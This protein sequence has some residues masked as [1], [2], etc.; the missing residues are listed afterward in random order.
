MRRFLP[1]FFCLIFAFMVPSAFAE[2]FLLK[3]HP[4]H[5]LD[6]YI[7]DALGQKEVS[8]VYVAE[9]GS[10]TPD[11]AKKRTSYQR[12]GCEPFNVMRGSQVIDEGYHCRTF[13][14]TGYR[15]SAKICRTN[16]GKPF[17]GIVEINRRTALVSAK[18]ERKDFTELT[19]IDRTPAVQKR[20]ADLAPLACAP[21]YM[22]HWG[23]VIGEGYRCQ[24]IGRYPEFSPLTE[25]I[26][27]WRHPVGFVCTIELAKEQMEARR[28]IVQRFGL[29]A[30]SAS[31]SM[32]STSSQASLSSSSAPAIPV[33]F[34]DVIS[35]YYGYTAILSLAERGVV[36]GYPDGTFR[37]KE[38]VNR[39]EF[40]KMLLVGL[41]PDKANEN[42]ACFPDIG[43]QWYAPYVCAAKRE[44]WVGGYPDGTFR[45]GQ[46]IRRA[47]GLKIVM[48]A[49]GASLD[50]NAPLPK[51]VSSGEWFTPYVRKAV[52]MRI[53]LEP[54]FDPTAPATR[55]DTA[56]WMYRASKVLSE[57]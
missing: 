33:G 55:A 29:N 9:L 3:D 43:N 20:I 12:I 38:S 47:E 52:E 45:A 28:A 44:G 40:L 30:S 36:R 1:A 25:C 11:Q 10:I 53:L 21:F 37:P 24:E 8:I 26:D 41:F 23:V 22:L 7:A 6:R 4:L 48:A 18:E 51:G 5:E 57:Q 2:L 39:A 56:V 42:G 54:A 16:E 46:P 17:G 27:D 14:C 19:G 15:T 13:F 50:S 34:K 32:S 35:G 49:L 31:S